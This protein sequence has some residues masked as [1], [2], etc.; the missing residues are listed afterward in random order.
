MA[1]RTL[2]NFSVAFLIILGSS[3]WQ[4]ATAQE[5]AVKVTFDD[6]VKPIFRQHCVSC[7]DPGSKLGGLDL[8]TY[9]GVMQGGSSG[10]VIEP[11]SAGDSYLYML[12]THESEPKMPQDAEKLAAADLDAIRNWIDAGVLENASSKAKL[13][14]KP[15]MEMASGGGTTRPEVMP[16]PKTLPLE[17]RVITQR[18]TAVTAM[19]TSPW[20]PLLA[21]GSEEQ[22]LLYDV[23]SLELVGVLPFPQGTPQVLKFSANGSLLLAGGGKAAHKGV[24]VVWNV[25]TGEQLLEVGDELDSVL[26]ADIS[27]DHQWIALGGPQRM[28]RIFSTADGSLEHEIKKHTDWVT[29]IAFSPDG[30]LLATG[31]RNGGLHVWETFTARPYADLRGHSAMI[32]G[33]SWRNDSNVVASASEDSTVRLWEMNAGNQIK[34]WNAHGGGTADVEFTRDGRLVSCGRDRLVKV[35]DQN[36]GQ[37]KQLQGFADLALAV[38]HCDETNRVI[39]GDWTG[40]VRV[41]NAEDA[42]ELGVLAANPPTLETRLAA[43]Q[44]TLSQAQTEATAKQQAAAAAKSAADQ[45]IA[46][47]QAAQKALTDAQATAQSSETA[48]AELQKKTQELTGQ[49]SQQTTALA[50]H[51][52]A[53]PNLKVAAEK[54]AEAAKAAA[55]DK[56]IA[57]LAEQL[58]QKLDAYTQARDGIAQS[59]QQT[60]TA[61]ATAAEETKTQTAARDTAQATIKESTAQ[62]ARLEPESQ[63]AAEAAQAAAQAQA[64]TDAALAAA[65]ASVEKWQSAI[66]FQEQWIAIQQNI[67]KAEEQWLTAQTKLSETQETAAA[68]ETALAAVA[69]AEAAA[70][71]ATTT[72]DEEIAKANTSKQALTQQI[73]TANEK[74]KTA[75]AESEATQ[76]AINSLQESLKHAQAV[77]ADAS[78][79]NLAAAIKSLQAAVAG[80]SEILTNL[81]TQQTTLQAEI[82]QANAAIVAADAAIATAQTQKQAAAEELAGMAEKKQAAQQQRDAT[83]AIVN[84]AETAAET[85]EQSLNN[86]REQLAAL[87]DA[88]VA[89]SAGD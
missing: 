43:A 70:Q 32:T 11:G 69:Q 81:A 53:L 47:L 38:T 22:V 79:E 26:A 68:A 18:A 60:Q 12:V 28:I 52:S 59:L 46:Q 82:N 19:A 61:L 77:A 45:K 7:H 71:Q 1:Y 50:Q 67:Q 2:V 13:S 27:A 17:P 72:A 3:S 4:A 37:Q 88:G 15:K 55:E 29:E 62:V 87:Q 73:T 75:Q 14:T 34:Q 5:E 48:L 78:D 54:A 31:D 85:A 9:T 84:E 39:A 86:A 33:L 49:S 8:S 41:W 30:V 25:E 21:L 66:A 23:N 74:I 44:Q 65:T 6:H 56:L 36:G 63:Q 35:W 24:A 10:A 80:R 83:Q 64:T 58:K 16:W 57:Q 51:D 76:Q 40:E 20:A 42:A 89:A